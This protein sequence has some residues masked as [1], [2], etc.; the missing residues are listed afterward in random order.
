MALCATLLAW[1]C[2]DSQSPDSGRV[3]PNDSHAGDPS[4]VDPASIPRWDGTAPKGSVPLSGGSLIV[5]PD[6]KTAVAAETMH[7]RVSVIDLATHAVRGRIDLPTGSEPGRLATD[8]AGRVHVVLRRGGGVADLDVGR[9][10]LAGLR[11]TC[12]LPRGIAYR[13]ADDALLVACASGELLTLAADPARSTPLARVMVT[14]AGQVLDDLRDVLAKDGVV[15]VTTFRSA[16]IARIG[17]DGVALQPPAAPNARRDTASMT[18][19]LGPRATPQ[20]FVPGVAWR[21]VVGS[22]GEIVVVHQA[23]TDRFIDLAP[24]PDGGKG[25]CGGS[26]YGGGSCDSTCVPPIVIGETST[27][28]GDTVTDGP[29]LPNGA[30]PVDIAA[31]RDGS[32]YTVVLAGN[33]AGTQTPEGGQVHNV[34]TVPSSQSLGG[35]LAG[36]ESLCGSPLANGVTVPGRPVA[37]DLDGQGDAVVLTQNPDAVHHVTRRGIVGTP[38]GASAAAD[39][40]YRL[41]HT[42]TGQGLACASCHPEGG[43]DGRVWRFT[44]GLDPMGAPGSPFVRRTQTFRAGFLDTAPFHWDGEFSGIPSL[45]ADVFVHRMGAKATP[46]AGDESALERWMN[47]VPA[48]IHERPA[49]PQAQAAERGRAVFEDSAVGCASCHSGP[50]LTNNRSADIGFGVPMQVPSLVDVAF[51][52]PYLHDG[53]VP[54]LDQRLFTAGGR[55]GKHG[56]T[57]HLSSDQFAD[58]VAYLKTL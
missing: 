52:A 36:G 1:G 11:Q 57:A 24:P 54:A 53:S 21:A 38:L 25:A 28:E 22:R 34:V 3:L 4:G 5:L 35:G 56:N 48:K 8:A 33:P 39:P 19:P 6:G 42:N 29:V 45:M 31:A 23:A 16:L 32:G 14:H 18:T 47:A 41:F 55:S 12:A 43:D 27:V 50:R 26:A 49:S 51:R 40:G 7:D 58:L 15:F 20:S 2:G 37:V 9:A 17:A 10:A 30:L 13:P 44:R 46:S